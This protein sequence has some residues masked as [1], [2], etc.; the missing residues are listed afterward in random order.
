M[1]TLVDHDMTGLDH[2]PTEI[3][4]SF[5]S[6]CSHTYQKQWVESTAAM[7]AEEAKAMYQ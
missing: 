3:R 5:D 4:I 7:D 2:F 1:Y 6:T